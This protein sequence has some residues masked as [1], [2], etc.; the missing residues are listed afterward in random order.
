MANKTI[1]ITFDCATGKVEAEAIGYDGTACSMDLDAVLRAAG[2]KIEER[3]PKTPAERNQQL[4]K[5]GAK[6]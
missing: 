1:A 6:S 4:L 2:V 3:R 5:T